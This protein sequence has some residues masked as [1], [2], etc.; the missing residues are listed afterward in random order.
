MSWA[1]FAREIFAQAGIAC[2]VRDIA[3]ADYP[4]PADRPLNSRLDCTTAETVFG[5]AKPDWRAGLGAILQE[6]GE[7]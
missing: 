7:G 4:T 1:G 2:E 5:L 6:L 3:S